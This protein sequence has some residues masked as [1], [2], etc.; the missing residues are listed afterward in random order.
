MPAL[1]RIASW[2]LI[3]LVLIGPAF[4]EWSAYNDCIRT[5]GGDNTA[6]N[7]TDWTI[8]NGYDTHNS[9]FL[10]DLQTGADL[11]VSVTFTMLNGLAVSNDSGANPV[12]GTDAYAVFHRP[13]ATENDWI[14]D[15]SG[16]ILY[17]GQPGWFVDI[18]FSGL[19][20]SKYYTFVG[21]AIRGRDYP[22]RESLFTIS[23]H[24]SAENNSSPGV[25]AKTPT[26]TTLLAGGNQ[27]ANTGFV[28]RWDKI[29]VSSSG[30]FTIRAEASPN[31]VLN[32]SGR[33][34]PFGAF[35]LREVGDV[36]VEPAGDL[37]DDDAI[38]LVDLML[39]AS[40]WLTAGTVADLNGDHIVNLQDLAILASNWQKS[41]K[42]GS[43]QATLTPAGAVA[44]GAKWCVDGGEWKD[45]GATITAIPIG[46]HTVSFSDAAGYTTP[47]EQ[48]VTILQNQTL[49]I[50]ADYV[51]KVGA[52]QTTILPQAAID[53][54]AQWRLDGGAWQNHDATV[55]DVPAGSHT[56]EFSAID[57]WIT[58][59]SQ[60]IE[61]V[62]GQMLGVTG[63]Y[64]RQT[65]TIQVAILPQGAIDAGAQWRI[66]GGTWNASG[67]TVSGVIVGEHTVEFGAAAGYIPPQN[68]TVLVEYNQTTTATGTYALQTGSL[69]ATI[70]PQGAIDDGAQWR[71]DG[72]TWRAGGSLV[73]GLAVGNHSVEYSSIAG[74]NT[75]Q[76]QTVVVLFG[77]TAATT[78]TYVRQTGSL[79]VVL[80]PAAAI[81]AG[82]QWRVDGGNWQVSGATVGDLFVGQHTVEFNEIA[83]YTKPGNQLAEIAK[84]QTAIL[85]GTYTQQTGS[86]QV[87]LSPAA[88]VT[89]GAQWRVD[90]GTWQAGG[91]TVSNLAVGAHTVEYLSVTGWDTPAE[92]SVTITHNQ[93]TTISGSYTEQTGS[94]TVTISPQAAI[95][96]G[97]QWRVDGGAWQISGATVGGLVIGSHTVEFKEATGFTTPASQTPTLQHNQT[98]TVTGAYV[99]QTG[100]IQTT[101]T[102]QGAID[103]GAR[104]RVDGGAWQTS[105]ATVSGLAIGSHTVE[106][107]SIAEWNNPATQSATVS[108][109]QT[110]AVS[111]A[112]VRHVGSLQT[113]ISPQGAID[114]GAQWRITGDIWRSS[115]ATVGNLPTGSYSV[116]YSA[117]SGW[118]PPAPQTVTIFQNQ[119]TT[120]AGIYE[121]QT[122]SLQVTITPSASVTAGAQW[123]V[124]GGAWQAPGTTVSGLAVGMHTVDYKAI[125]GW[126]T[127]E[128]QS[129]AVSNQQ[130]ATA[131]GVYGL[132]TGALQ[133]TIAPQG[134]IDAQARWRVDGGAW[135]LS[136]AVVGG[137]A[138]GGHAVEFNAITGYDSPG[139]QTV[140]VQNGQTTTLTATY[141]L[142]TG[143]ITVTIVP[144][145]AIDAGAYWRADNG[146]WRGSGTTLTP[147]AIGWHEIEY[148]PIS[149]WT[150]PTAQN[151][152]VQKDATTATTGTYGQVLTA[153]L[154]ISEFMADNKANF[155][156]QMTAGG[157]TIYP[158]WIEIYNP[159]DTAVNLEGWSLKTGG[160]RWIFPS[161]LLASGQY[162]IVCATGQPDASWPVLD[163]N[164]YYHTNFRLDS[165][166]EYL[167]LLAPDGTIIFEYPDGYPQ[168]LEDLS[169]GKAQYITPLIDSGAG[170]R[171]RVPTVSDPTGWTQA[172]FDDSGWT[173]ETTP[174]GFGAS[175][176]PGMVA[177]Y[178]MNEGAGTVAYDKLGSHNGTLRGTVTWV[179]GPLNGALGT[180]LN[181]A[182][183]YG[184]YLDIGNWN[185]SAA[186][187][188]L[189]ISHWVKWSG[190]GNTWQGTIGKRDTWNASDMMWQ[191]ELQTNSSPA[192]YTTLKQP[193]SY[194]A[195]GFTMPVNQWIHLAMSFDGTLSTMYLN[196]AS[197][198][199]D[200][201]SFASD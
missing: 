102:P 141:I 117:V 6:A 198:G 121:L 190:S 82:A 53:A 194:P 57:G 4:A 126:I 131:V 186:T 9:G 29:Q 185:P 147:V 130:T 54:G 148:L 33:A 68:Q 159:T 110:T 48:T 77:A 151:I 120:T 191:I 69:Q 27:Y 70:A 63:T 11:P 10:K 200:L 109:N 181:F 192:G 81:T 67:Q 193:N 73:E 62:L 166:G 127:P 49:S 24:Q 108:F 47:A 56:I 150:T 116:D 189:S 201:F 15:L 65:G 75:P 165:S 105:G 112:Y 160:N 172:S 34:Y 7:V 175:A 74:W 37:N 32:D 140:Q 158:D 124:D 155:S 2:M 78:G 66:D 119:T 161:I 50:S 111:G 197:I 115:G 39:L 94:L 19:N 71:V 134:A 188:Q 40:E 169:Y 170:I 45:S 92:Q 154:T 177:Y 76:T 88:A 122:G 144:Q 17:Y 135:Q 95:D 99:L 156:T 167:G 101:I 176:D 3:M 153:A 195:Y 133:I 183:N 164:G 107:N 79:Q 25:V 118:N 51:L 20:P 42:S 174:L 104:W 58:P 123:R 143:S 184:D 171:W 113:T 114:A 84:D 14:V 138:V 43:L 41:W 178:P 1:H 60:A 28:V 86:L 103:A 157:A 52:V 30:T 61:V 100:S 13:N 87:T 35:L 59:A 18:T 16:G 22:L 163:A 55:T 91:A 46:S 149:G 90:G 21:T 196:G 44:A 129:V 173:A 106:F 132:Q 89:A 182:G 96:A 31:A 180:A 179:A 85:T 125:T 98:A 72:G 145:G 36:V 137:L 142:H 8:Y 139:G 26:T 136:D 38:D 80:E 187:G 64:E 83:G 93:T 146:P 12:A 5:T 97:A 128:T 168:Q 23:G 162:L 152:L 199:S